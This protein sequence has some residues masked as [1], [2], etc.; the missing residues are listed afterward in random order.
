MFCVHKKVFIEL[1]MVFYEYCLQHRKTS[2]LFMVFYEYC[3][4]HRK[5]SNKLKRMSTREG[6]STLGNGNSYCYQLQ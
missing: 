5:T 3:L 4:Q 6:S 2:K 1:F